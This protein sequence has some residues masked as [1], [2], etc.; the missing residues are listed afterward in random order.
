MF[1]YL[2]NE[3]GKFQRFNKVFPWYF[4]SSII[5]S[6]YLASRPVGLFPLRLGET[7]IATR[8]PDHRSCCHYEMAQG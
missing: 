3:D 7:P 2:G 4:V 5:F 1:L 8:Q 6:A